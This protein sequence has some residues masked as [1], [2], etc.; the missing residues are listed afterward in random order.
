MNTSLQ[1]R[2]PGRCV[3]C[4]ALVLGAA[5]RLPVDEERDRVLRLG[6]TVVWLARC[7]ACCSTCDDARG[8]RLVLKNPAADIDV[9]R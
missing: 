8:D 4:G 1:R 9:V 7:D 3:N 6:N 2:S 5:D